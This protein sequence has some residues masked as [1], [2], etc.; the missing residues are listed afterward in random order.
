V[1]PASVSFGLTNT[2]AA[3]ADVALAVLS[4]GNAGSEATNADNEAVVGLPAGGLYNLSA[5]V[6][7]NASPTPNPV[8]G[9]S[10]TFVVEP[11]ATT[12][13]GTT[14]SNIVGTTDVNGVVNA[15][16]NAN[17]AAGGFTVRAVVSGVSAPGATPDSATLTNLAGTAAALQIVS[18]N[19]QSQVVSGT[20]STPLVVR[21]RR[22]LRQCG[23]D[24]EHL[25]HVHGTA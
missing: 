9:V 8:P 1:T 15:T 25:G 23:D 16:F 10:V 19:N 22:C 13:A 6:V 21:D 17:T 11:N 18:G 24:A 4:D 5:T 3:P 14:V 20:F 12:G 2:A 7:D